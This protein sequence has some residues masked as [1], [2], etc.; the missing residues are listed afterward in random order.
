MRLKLAELKKDLVGT[1]TSPALR[2]SVD[3]V[4][5][6]WLQIQLYDLLLAGRESEASR[7]VAELAKRQDQAHRRYQQSLK[8]LEILRQLTERHHRDLRI[9]VP[10]AAPLAPTGTE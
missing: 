2:L 6:C 1:S 5:A 9:H 10:S 3:R 8:A 7:Q 4:A